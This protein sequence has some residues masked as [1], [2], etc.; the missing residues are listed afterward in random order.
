MRQIEPPPQDRTM[1]VQE[2]SRNL[3]R[4]ATKAICILEK[5]IKPVPY[6]VWEIHA[7][8]PKSLGILLVRPEDSHEKTVKMKIISSFLSSGPP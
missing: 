8:T 5:K 4:L 1:H 7:V 3:Q 2:V 6:I